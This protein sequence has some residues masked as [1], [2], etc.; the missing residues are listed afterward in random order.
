[1]KSQS[2]LRDVP[3][4]RNLRRGMLRWLV[5][6]LVGLPLGAHPVPL[7]AQ[8]GAPQNGEW[9]T[10]GGDPGNSKYSPLDQITRDNF[11]RLKVA[12]RWKSVDGFL[13]K[14]APGGGEVWGSSNVIFDQLNK[15]NPKR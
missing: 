4:A 9:R 6:A 7:H 14:A 15:E 13:S 2:C 5:V 8:R 12:W 1:M 11:T 3:A 10:Y